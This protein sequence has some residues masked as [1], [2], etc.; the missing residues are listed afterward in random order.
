MVFDLCPK[1]AWVLNFLS[2]LGSNNYLRSLFL[3]SR[4]KLPLKTI[5]WFFRA[6]W[7]VYTAPPALACLYFLLV[8]MISGSP[9]FWILLYSTSGDILGSIGDIFVR[10]SYPFWFVLNTLMDPFDPS[11]LKVP[12][13]CLN[14]APFL[15]KFWR[16]KTFYAFWSSRISCI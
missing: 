12:F 2:M 10:L 7:M 8:S 3:S 15:C 1:E 6:I 11:V 14:N 13:F 5:S 9:L 4:V 16:L